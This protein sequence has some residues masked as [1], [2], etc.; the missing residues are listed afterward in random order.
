MCDRFVELVALGPEL[1]AQAERRGEGVN[2]A[3][4]LVHEV[5]TQAFADLQRMPSDALRDHLSSQLERKL[6]D[7]RAAVRLPCRR[8][9]VLRARRVFE[10]VPAI[11]KLI[12]EHSAHQRRNAGAVSGAC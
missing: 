4:F 10:R 9:G 3:H 11:W 12:S 1:R 8:T 6:G 2:E 5:L 7:R